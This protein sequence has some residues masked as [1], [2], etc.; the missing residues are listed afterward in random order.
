FSWGKSALG[1]RRMAWPMPLPF[2]EVM[3]Q[4]MISSRQE[5]VSDSNDGQAREQLSEFLLKLY[6][7]GIV[8]FR[9]SLPPIARGAS[10]RPVASP[11]ARWQAQHGEVVT[12]LFH[13]A[14]KVE[15][16]IGR[17][18]LSWL[19]GTLDRKALL[20]KL[21]FLLESNK[22]LVIPNGDETAARREIELGLQ[23]NLEKLA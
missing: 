4:A 6:S 13:I 16:E 19:D 10:E 17:H 2:E 3:Q 15:D 23:N 22:A 5:Q 1:A 9:A 12:A 14:V 11:V 7:A 20:E 21:W 8:E 18:L